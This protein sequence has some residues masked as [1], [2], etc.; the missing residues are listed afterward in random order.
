MGFAVNP[1]KVTAPSPITCFLGIDID[2]HEGAAH[3]DPDCLEAITHELT[4]FW[5]AKLAM[6]WEVLSLIGKWHFVCRV[7]PPG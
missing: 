3:I 4:G 2:S 5:Q 7:C 1:S 6:K